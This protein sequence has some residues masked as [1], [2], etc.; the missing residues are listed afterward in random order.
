MRRH[1]GYAGALGF[2][3]KI[4]AD[5]AQGRGRGPLRVVVVGA[6]GRP[7]SGRF[8]GG[9]VDYLA[10]GSASPVLRKSRSAKMD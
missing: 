6:I 3:G 5:K 1:D 2:R 8:D 4:D 10:Q 7:T 9:F